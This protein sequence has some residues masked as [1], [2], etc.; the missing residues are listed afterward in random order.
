MNKLM[1]IEVFKIIQRIIMVLLT[2]LILWAMQY[3]GSEIYNMSDKINT[4]SLQLAEANNRI[5]AL[6]GQIEDKGGMMVDVIER[7]EKRLGRSW[8]F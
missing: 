4:M 6:T 5:Q 7:L 1:W 8:F 2:L 3:V